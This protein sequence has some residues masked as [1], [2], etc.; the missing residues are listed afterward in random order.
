MRQYLIFGLIL[1]GLLFLFLPGQNYYQTLKIVWREPPVKTIGF[2]PPAPA[3][4]PVFLNKEQQPEISAES[5]IIMD[6]SSAV[7]MFQKN[8]NEK[9]SP[10][11]TT[12]IMT[13]VVALENYKLTDIFTVKTLDI[14][15]AQMGLRNGEKLTVESLLYG[16]L[17]NSGNDAAYTLAESFPGG[18]EQFIYAMNKKANELNLFNTRFSNFNG[19]VEPNHYTTSLDLA[20]LA[21]YA[22]SSEE[23]AKIVGISEA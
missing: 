9:L 6:V 2:S 1:T 16:L 18:I 14:T 12:K 4:Y 22:L 8:P 7:A 3:K 10:A 17:I 15:G 19:L 21:V 23:F 11:S 5:A 20:R 13:A